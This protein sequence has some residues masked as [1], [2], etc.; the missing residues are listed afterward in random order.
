MI[1]RVYILFQNCTP[2]T[3]FVKII[4]YTKFHTM[5]FCIL[6]VI[7]KKRLPYYGNTAS[8]L[9]SLSMAGSFDFVLLLYHPSFGMIHMN[10]FD[11]CLTWLYFEVLF[12]TRALA[13]MF[14]GCNPQNV[15]GG[16]LELQRFIGYKHTS[17]MSCGFFCS[18]LC[19]CR[20]GQSKDIFLKALFSYLS[21]D[22]CFGCFQIVDGS[23]SSCLSD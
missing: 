21:H 12:L 6:K 18:L 11:L 17:Y 10:F 13:P 1:L 22:V 16:R 7:L 4:F 5:A 15:V 23:E 3:H 14:V 9:D 2:F 8:L 20:H 19:V